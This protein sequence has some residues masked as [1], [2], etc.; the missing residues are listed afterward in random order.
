M[1]AVQTVTILLVRHGESTANLDA[2]FAG[3]Y[4]VPLTDRG[5]AQAEAA[6]AY[7]AAQYAVDAVYA[8]D[9][10]RARE[11]AE[12]IANRFRLPVVP[13]RG[14]REINAGCWEGRPF[15]RLQ[16]EYADDYGKWLS[17]IGSAVCTGGESV[18]ALQARVSDALTEI[19]RAE[20][21][22][23]EASSRTVAIVTHA[24]PIRAMQCLWL[25]KPL[26][27][28]RGFPYVTNATVT[29]AVYDG[30]SFA[31]Q[32]VGVDG[33]LAALRTELPKSV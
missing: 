22:R 13:C 10:R 6:A 18:A 15:T 4:D 16:C 23:A 19:A 30:A 9:L 28:M 29:C 25:G 3:H 8:S 17:D 27:A 12:H 33:Y 24:A 26:S 32:A 1:D 31:L 7:I 14:L 21:D 5:H 11:T 20:R 2:I